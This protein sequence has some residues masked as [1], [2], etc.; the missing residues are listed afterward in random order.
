MDIKNRLGGVV[1]WGAGVTTLLV[2]PFFSY[3]P[4][5]VPRILSLIVFGSIGLFMLI[6]LKKEMLATKYRSVVIASFFFF[7]WALTAMFASKMNLVD[8]IFGVSGRQTGFL[9]YFAFII[10]MICAVQSAGDISQRRIALTLV[11]LGFA[12]GLY[13]VLQAIGG[14]PFDW[15]NPYSPVFGLFGN[16]NFH[17]SFMGMTAVAA[18]AFSQES[19][20]KL[21]NRLPFL[22]LV[23]LA[24]FN[25]YQS[26]SQQGY[27]TF[28]AGLTVV[29]F[30]YIRKHKKLQ[31]LKISYGLT[32]FLG[33]VI[34]LLDVLQKSPW[35]SFFYKDSVSFRGDFWRAGWK[36]T[37]DNPIFG[38]GLDG[39]RDNY[40]TSRDLVSALRVG[41]DEMTDSAHNIFLDI[42][43]GGG[44]PLLIIYL[45]LVGLTI[46]SA[47]KVIRR[48][49]G[50]D[51]GFAAVLGAWVAYLAQSMISINQIGLAVWGWVLMGTIIGYE[52][53]SREKIEVKSV[54][55]AYPSV[56]IGLGLIIGLGVG[57]PLMVADTKFRTTLKSGDVLKIE[58]SVRQWPQSVTRLTAVAQLL[59]QGNFP[60]RSIVI[61]REAVELN[62]L[63]YE[64][65]RELSLQP[66]ATES[67]RVQALETMKKLDPFNPNLK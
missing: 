60:E 10:L 54:K 63:N 27:L 29:G 48:S 59:R 55:S 45:F 7:A 1:L 49:T 23:L 34:F 3:D 18:V 52:I 31:K 39:Y 40:R 57:L 16:P 50:F 20:L 47:V 58:A 37:I 15:I 66:N 41:S 65:W 56:A 43:S 46:L 53:N 19:G 36:M 42:S 25:I 9:T 6:G 21:K 2:T 24:I 8:G 5:N 62:P 35:N 14:D 26:K 30:L 61:A 22:M 11:W 17:A 13:G 32:V 28:L 33:L 64:A 12:S 4:I 44:F 67:E 38:L 51:V